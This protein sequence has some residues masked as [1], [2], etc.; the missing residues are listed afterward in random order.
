VDRFGIGECVIR[1][2]QVDLAAS[3]TTISRLAAAL[4]RDGSYESLDVRRSMA[5]GII[6]D[7]TRAQALLDDTGAP[8]PASREVFA[9]LHLSDAN[10][11][12]V[13]PV[14]LDH[15]GR[16]HLT[17]T[18]ATWA[19]RDD[20]HLTITPVHHCTGCPRCD[21]T[22]G[23]HAHDTRATTR[24]DPLARHRVQVEPQ[25]PTCAFP[26]CTR[27][28]RSCDLDHR[29]PFPD[30]AT[31]PCNLAPLCR[32][33]HRLTTHA[34]WRYRPRGPAGSGAYDWTDRYGQEF[35]RTRD[36]TVRGQSSS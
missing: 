16:P 8:V 20:T 28:T 34:G 21:K 3:E 15:T 36:G 30:G 17:Q 14:T 26:Y 23:A 35:T 2:D 9:Y 5:V 19:G 24:H 1:A 18:V 12:G 13:D 31:C 27:P 4:K 25:D 32:H 10:L 7:P 29:V 11:L 33:H 22:R 6:A